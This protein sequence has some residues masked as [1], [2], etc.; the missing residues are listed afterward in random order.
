MFLLTQL[1]P[2]GT[3]A[4]N[5]PIVPT[6]DDYEDGEFGCMM[7][8]RGNRNTRRKSAPVPLCPPQIPHDLTGR[9]RGPPRWEASD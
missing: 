9:E 7:I 8:G 6:P 1:R 4:T 2:R 5:C 3:S